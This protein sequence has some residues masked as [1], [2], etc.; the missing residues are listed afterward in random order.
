MAS[1]KKGSTV[2]LKTFEKYDNRA[3]LG[4]NIEEIDGKDS[5]LYLILHLIFTIFSSVHNLVSESAVD[6]RPYTTIISFLPET[7]LLVLKS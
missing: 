5:T 2:A 1:N 7:G 3:A 6:L 4:T